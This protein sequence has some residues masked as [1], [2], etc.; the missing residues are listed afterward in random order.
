MPAFGN[1]LTEEQIMFILEFFKSKWGVEAR[2]V[3]WWMSVRPE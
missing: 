2:E 3:Q 1:K